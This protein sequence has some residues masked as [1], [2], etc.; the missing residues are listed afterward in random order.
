MSL[1]S[2]GLA[3]FG[4]VSTLAVAFQ[5]ATDAPARAGHGQRRYWHRISVAIA[6][7]HAVAGFFVAGYTGVLLAAT[8]V[9]LW[10]K[11]PAL[12]GPLFLAS[13]MSSGAAAVAAAA[14]LAPDSH[15]VHSGLRELE[16]LASVTEGA[17]LVSW[18]VSLGP[19][20]KPMS[21]GRLG[22]LV[23]HG[24]AGAGIALPLLLT[25]ASGV[26]PRRLRRPAETAASLLSLAGV[27]A[28]RFAVVEGG[29][30]S[31]DDPQATFEMTG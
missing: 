15:E 21:T 2:W 14:S 1:G 29:R 5:I 31:A 26:L 19:T 16:A 9:P 11:R 22:R 12:L 23:R 3:I 8:A 18:I 17:L 6:P 27:L 24:I 25:A 30:L 4:G 28:L 13:A 20:A 10:S 7:L